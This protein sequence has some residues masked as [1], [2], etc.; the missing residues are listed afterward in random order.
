M[1]QLKMHYF[2]EHSSFIIKSKAL[3][4]KGYNEFRQQFKNKTTETSS[5][6]ASTYYLHNTTVNI[7]FYLT[8][9]II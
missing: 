4:K 3:Y 9:F 1:T 5:K 2:A 8:Q 7:R 6:K